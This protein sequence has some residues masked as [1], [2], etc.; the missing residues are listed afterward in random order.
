MIYRIYIYIFY[1]VQSLLTFTH[2]EIERLR[3]APTSLSTPSPFSG[4]QAPQHTLSNSSSQFLKLSGPCP[5]LSRLR[6]LLLPHFHEELRP[7]GPAQMGPLS[8]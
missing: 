8:T 6:L 5:A 4:S 2:A 7:A 1:P 3:K